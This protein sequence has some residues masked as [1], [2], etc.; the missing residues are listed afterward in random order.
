MLFKDL[1]LYS[2]M[3][4]DVFQ[5][6]KIPLYFRRGR[7]LLSG[8][9]AKTILSIFQLLDTN[10]ERDTFLKI[11][12]SNYVDCWD[13]E[14]PLLREKVEW[15]I[16][17]AGIIDDRDNAWDRKL[18]RL[19]ER[20]RDKRG[21]GPCGE[22]GNA[23]EVL[24]EYEM[25]KRLRDRVLWVKKELE[26]FRENT[27]IERFCDTLKRLICVLGMRK[28]IMCCN[29]EDIVKRDCATLKKIEQIL[30]AVVSL[31]KGLDIR[32]EIVTYRYFRN[33][34]LKF[35]EESFILAGR[36]ADHGVKVLN[37]Y[38]S[39]GL[40]FDYLFLG[41][42]AE[43]SSPG[44]GWEDPFITDEDKA[45][46]NHTAGKKIFLLKD[47]EWE[48]EPLL[49]YLGL[50]CARKRLYLSYSQMDAQGR[51]LLPSFYLNELRRLLGTEA[52]TVL[53]SDRGLVIP[54]FSE[55]YEEEEMVNRLTLSLWRTFGD[56]TELVEDNGSEHVL[57]PAL[58]NHLI[59]HD[60][61][62]HALGK[63]FYC[64]EIEKT[65]EGFF[66]EEDLTRRK[67]QASVWTG[68]INQKELLQELGDF[69]ERGE[70]HMWSPTYFESYA[71]CP[72][73]FFLERVLHVYSLGVPEEEI[74]KVDEGTL[75]HTVLERFFTARKREN[76]LPLCGSRE[77]KHCIHS[78]ADAVYEKW[79]EEGAIGNRALWEIRK[80]KVA[81]LWDRFI[82][83][84]SQFW[85]EGLMPTFF[86]FLIGDSSGV[87]RDAA[88]PALLFSDDDQGEIAVRGKVDRIDIGAQK[89]RIIDYKNTRSES[90]YRNLLKNENI[91]TLNFQ[92][93]VYLAAAREYL[94]ERY[95]FNDMEATYYLFGKGKR[96]KP[97]GINASDPFF[98]KDLLKRKKLNEQ[99]RGNIFNRMAAIVRAAKS[100]D[101]SICPQSCSF[102]EY[103]HVC[104]FV[105]VEIKETTEAGE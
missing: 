81:P 48:E 40:T 105:A 62:R 50:S 1:S 47:E 42:C 55:C 60:R 78:I 34:L 82:E 77:E 89:V 36:E 79:E 12:Q 95:T 83:E 26:V 49:F 29:D 65:R 102:C 14:H 10:F 74:E 44:K 68:M 73:R 104:R 15:F 38:E 31:A 71:G 11:V 69:F 18:S 28:A 70:G 37:F 84:E 6:F 7:P 16:L 9:V 100:G 21:Q 103:K 41:G 56:D 39:R 67:A 87:E 75:I 20:T 45:Q 32:D 46:F 76:R 57:T 23:A 51:T 35:M 66:L 93:P 19:M 25:V 90:H 30:D 61:F 4:E 92:I 8:T 3:V 80:R 43:D 52:G 63:I 2:E 85:E 27:T 13:G 53:K 59:V 94:F 33:L 72:F 64:A 101:F 5:R 54:Y 91:G 22:G 98:E 99:G 97:Y 88:M 96:V 58:F 86:E 17:R 24:T